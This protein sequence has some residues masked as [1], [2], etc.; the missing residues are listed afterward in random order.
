MSHNFMCAFL[1]VINLLRYSVVLPVAPSLGVR[2][3]F[4]KQV[5]VSSTGTDYAA[6]LFIYATHAMP[7]SLEKAS[8][9]VPN[10]S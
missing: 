6:A 9:S 4:Y 2:V 7:R 8:V 10:F 3:V 5:P 1:K